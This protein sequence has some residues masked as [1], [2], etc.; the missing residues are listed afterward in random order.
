MNMLEN[1]IVEI[2]DIKMSIQY[3]DM[4]VWDI[5]ERLTGFGL[6]C[7]EQVRRR[8]DCRT[9]VVRINEEYTARGY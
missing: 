2:K 5:R 8:C 4:Q 1:D 6:R 7:R 3:I 9:E